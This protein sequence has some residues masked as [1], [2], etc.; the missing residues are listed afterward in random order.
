ML[1]IYRDAET[2]RSY[3]FAQVKSTAIEFG[4]GLKA[5]WEW[6]KGDVLALFTPNCIDT[7]PVIWGALWAG[8]IV[9]PANSG[10]KAV[11]L[12][13]QL[14][15]SG[16]KALVTQR[17]CLEVAQDA[18]KQAGIPMDRI[19]LTGEKADI[20]KGFRHFT[21][22]INTAEGVRYRRTKVNPENDLAFL[23]YSSGTTGLPKGVMLSHENITANCLMLTAGEGGHLTWNGGA[24]NEGDK[25]IEFLPF[26][27]VYGAFEEDLE[28][29]F[30]C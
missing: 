5:R 6:K 1:V 25:T 19:I 14:R 20:P 18:A 30:I 29:I 17:Q 21:A 13:F 15:D 11:E 27:H 16:A 22:I 10:Y 26:Y 2:G 4:T 23:V 9:S 7:P 8:A 12:A 28:K 3:T 24:N